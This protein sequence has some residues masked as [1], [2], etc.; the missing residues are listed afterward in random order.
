MNG[1]SG[2]AFLPQGATRSPLVDDK[3]ATIAWDGD[4][5]SGSAQGKGG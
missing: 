1:R 2:C 3:N 4:D 5:D